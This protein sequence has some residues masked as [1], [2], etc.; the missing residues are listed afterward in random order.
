[1][2]LMGRDRNLDRGDKK[3][4]KPRVRARGRS[5]ARFQIELLE[6]RVLLFG[7]P[8]VGPFQLIP[9]ATLSLQA[10]VSHPTP[11]PT[12]SNNLATIVPLASQQAGDAG[13]LLDPPLQQVILAAPQYTTP[14]AVVDRGSPIGFSGFRLISLIAGNQAAFQDAGSPADFT[15][16]R[17]DI[18][19]Q[20]SE[21]S[22]VA[23]AL[24]H[25]GPISSSW[26][27][28]QSE[29]G[30]TGPEMVVS[31]IPGF[32]GLGGGFSAPGG[33]HEAMAGTLEPSHPLFEIEFTIETPDE[34]FN[35]AL[36]HGAGENGMPPAFMMKMFDTNG[37]PL[38][39][40]NPEELGPP[41]GAPPDLNV[42]L[43]SAPVGGKLVVQV[44]PSES[45][46]SAAG[47]VTTDPAGSTGD[48]SVPFVLYVQRQDDEA[49]TASNGLPTQGVIA[50][51]TLALTSSGQVVQ[52][53]SFD[54]PAVA[55][56]TGAADPAPSTQDSPPPAT[57]GADEPALVSADGFNL[58]V[59]T[60]PFASRTAG[61]LGPILAGIGTEPTPEVDRNEG[62][63]FHE[64]ERR[65]ADPGF[66]GGDRALEFVQAAD[67]DAQSD[68][69]GGRVR[70]VA[71][72]G[73]F[74]YKVTGLTNGRRTNLR[75]LLA[76]I[77]V[78]AE[79]RGS[80]ALT[81]RSIGPIAVAFSD[82]APPQRDVPVYV[83]FIKAACGLALGL[84]MSS[85]A[86]FPDL[87]SSMRRRV[88]KWPRRR[89][90]PAGGAGP[91]S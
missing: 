11:G 66:L 6:T 73:G 5:C 29:N 81:A 20:G 53:T 33:Y 25:S 75:A 60:G 17:G 7:G 57:A 59:P 2:A 46:T 32:A 82:E 91:K 19:V 21:P 3:S 18:G 14:S 34:S 37:N 45:S 86:V 30:Q 35:F 62:A 71:G 80:S 8:F 78:A 43:R 87:L 89:Q 83:G 67:P 44:T 13:T 72:A 65:E 27:A 64:I 88:S 74:V 10:V 38:A 76:S 49:Q 1:V 16:Q 48:W 77:P 56:A 55:I 63:L 12:A 40:Y 22:V 39:E 15:V 70:A 4:R 79:E 61:P 90:A 23:S 68:E 24:D 31:P 54:G 28:S 36:L 84:G 52:P 50:A 51:G 58:R 26:Y 47:T 41:G 85:R 42:S 69:L 9:P